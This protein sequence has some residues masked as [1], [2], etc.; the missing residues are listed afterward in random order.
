MFGHKFISTVYLIS[1]KDIGPFYLDE[2]L[3][4]LQSETMITLLWVYGIA[5]LLLY[6]IFV[7]SNVNKKALPFMRIYTCFFFI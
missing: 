1:T 7:G 3:T 5:A 6:T 2:P 4:P